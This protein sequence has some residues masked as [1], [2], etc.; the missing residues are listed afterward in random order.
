MTAVTI[1]CAAAITVVH[2]P[3]LHAWFVGDDLEKIWRATSEGSNVGGLSN[4]PSYWRLTEQATLRLNERL[5]G[6]DPVWFHA[7]NV[8]LHVVVSLL[9][10]LASVVLVRAVR[11]DPPEGTP[12]TRQ[13]CRTALVAVLV[14]G[15]LPSHSEAVVWI[16]GRGDLLMTLFAVS[17]ALLHVSARRDGP[18]LPMRVLAGSLALVAFAAALLSKESAVAVL[19]I[20]AVL[21]TARST[22]ATVRQR[23]VEALRSIWPYLV[24]TAVW[25]VVRRIALGSF[26]GGFGTALGELS[27][28][29]PLRHVATLMARTLLPPAPLWFWAGIAVAVAIVLAALARSWRRPLPTAL[30]PAVVMAICWIVAVLPVA[31]LGASLVDPLGERLLYLPSVFAVLAA[32]QL[33][34]LL[35]QRRPA[36]G[37]A[38]AV[39]TVAA[40][41]LLLIGQQQRWTRA[42]E[43]SEQVVRELGALPRDR[44]AVLLNAPDTYDGVYVTRNAVTPALVLFHGWEDPSMVWQAASQQV[45]TTDEP[46][47]V[48]STGSRTWRLTIPSD[49]RR[50]GSDWTELWP[51]TGDGVEQITV[52]QES[53]AAIQVG[54]SSDDA[55]APTDDVSSV[56]WFSGGRLRPAPPPRN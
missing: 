20:L 18:A 5:S 53:P 26:V 7:T 21:D 43:L 46:T 30:G 37:G 35:D 52:E 6:L 49:A 23:V 36:A 42:G 14:F 16:A 40:M 22:A 31:G 19:G 32:V 9:V 13:E 56:W 38:V 24:V 11:R 15:M 55:N 50:R 4:P 34:A 8:A 1:G 10:G 2:L 39:V 3:S 54:V 45:T 12:W 44:P 25:L 27:P 51:R 41:S 33:W 48:E 29:D 28:L 47:S 17:T